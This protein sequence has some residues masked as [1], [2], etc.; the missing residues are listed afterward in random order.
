LYDILPSVP[1]GKGEFGPEIVNKKCMVSY[2]LSDGSTKW[3]EAIVAKHSFYNMK[4]WHY[5]QFTNGDKGQWLFIE[6]KGI[7]W[8]DETSASTT[9]ATTT[10]ATTTTATATTAC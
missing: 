9:S 3:F 2:R 5:I 8:I 1:V 6:S 10:S 4:H 7:R